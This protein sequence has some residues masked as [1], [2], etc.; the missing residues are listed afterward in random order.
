MIKLGIRESNAIRVLN[1]GSTYAERSKNNF[2]DRI[3]SQFK[4]SPSYTEVY[5]NNSATL[6]GVNIVDENV[7]QKD[8]NKKRILMHPGDVINVGDIVTWHDNEW[9]CT[10]ND[11]DNEV[12][13]VGI[14]ERCNNH[15]T[16]LTPTSQLITTPCIIS[17][18][19]LYTSGIQGTKLIITP[20]TKLNIVCPVNVNTLRFERGMR[21]LIGY[22]GKYYA[23]KVSMVDLVSQVGLLN[24][25]VEEDEIVDE[26]NL[27]T[28]LAY[29]QN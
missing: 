5:I 21:F 12:Y 29:N 27:D 15:L 18:K 16:Y 6:T 26:D 3:S 17:N 11:L 10:D 22:S 1:G 4:N 2:V 25:V 20:D 13:C 24:I 8:S 28:G 14:I 23:Y 7:L 9:I 19:S